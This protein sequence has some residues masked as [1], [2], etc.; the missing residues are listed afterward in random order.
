MKVPHKVFIFWQIP[1]NADEVRLKRLI[2]T[3]RG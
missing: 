3:K 1:E 2:S